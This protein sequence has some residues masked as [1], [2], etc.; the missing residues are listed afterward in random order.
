MASGPLRPLC[1][2]LPA[3][4][5]TP[6][7]GDISSCTHPTPSTATRQGLHDRSEF[8][9]AGLR[10]VSHVSWGWCNTVFLELDS[11]D[12][13]TS[14]MVDTLKCN[15]KLNSAAY[16]ATPHTNIH[17]GAGGRSQGSLFPAPTPVS[18]TFLYV[19]SP[20]AST[21]RWPS[22]FPWPG[23]GCPVTNGAWETGTKNSLG[24]KPE[25]SVSAEG[26]CA[27]LGRVTRAELPVVL[28]TCHQGAHCSQSPDHPHAILGAPALPL[29][30]STSSGVSLGLPF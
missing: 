21:P 27:V 24:K 29:H 1:P 6:T 5:P 30:S 12:H 16:L 20:D 28:Y 11:R 7:P 14:L 4:H 2:V 25:G 8:W 10:G 19:V 18:G 13:V 9:G 15:C 23:P 26:C 22:F 3:P 17:A